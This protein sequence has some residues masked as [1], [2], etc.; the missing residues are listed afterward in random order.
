MIMQAEY[1]EG[2]KDRKRKEGDIPGIPSTEGAEKLRE[3]INL[4]KE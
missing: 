1:I 3:Y 2:L 4:A